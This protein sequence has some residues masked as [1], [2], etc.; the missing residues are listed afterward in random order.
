M[1]ITRPDAA[2]LFVVLDRFDVAY[3]CSFGIEARDSFRST[4]TEKIPALIQILFELAAPL[5]LGVGGTTFSFLPEELV[6]LVYQLA[7]PLSKVLIFHPGSLTALGMMAPA[8]D[9]GN[10]RP[11]RGVPGAQ[12]TLYRRAR[13]AL[14]LVLV[15]PVASSTNAGVW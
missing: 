2:S 1:V 3:V 13:R 12:P 5:S 9:I 11:R 4:L 14:D 6:L 8:F 7:D 15:A 10:G